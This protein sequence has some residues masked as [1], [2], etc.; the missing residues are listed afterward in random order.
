[1]LFVCGR[2]GEPAPGRAHCQRSDTREVPFRIARIVELRDRVSDLGMARDSEVERREH[3]ARR[4][5]SRRLGERRNA[6]VVMESQLPGS[7]LL[8]PNQL[9]GAEVLV[10]DDDGAAVFVVRPQEYA[11]TTPKSAHPKHRVVTESHGMRIA[12][13]G[14]RRGSD[15]ELRAANQNSA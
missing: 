10:A 3:L 4:A 5:E 2:V 11:T 14:A 15:D 8:G 6:R 1:M 13:E 9:R 7:V 12:N